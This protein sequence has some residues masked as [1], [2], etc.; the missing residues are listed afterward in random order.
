MIPII[1][2]SASDLVLMSSFARSVDGALR[3]P[4][5]IDGVS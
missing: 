5:T 4:P 2:F 1:L 3:V